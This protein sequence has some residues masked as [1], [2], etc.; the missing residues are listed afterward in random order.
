VFKADVTPFPPY[1][2][3]VSRRDAQAAKLSNIDHVGE[4]CFRDLELFDIKMTFSN[5]DLSYGEG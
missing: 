3:V 1:V 4:G 2:S 5:D